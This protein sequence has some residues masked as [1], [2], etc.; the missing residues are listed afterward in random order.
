MLS[1]TLRIS[2]H[3]RLSNPNQKDKIQTTII[4]IITILIMTT[5]KIIKK[6]ANAT[7]WGYEVDLSLVTFTTLKTHPN[8]PLPQWSLC[9]LVEATVHSANT[10]KLVQPTKTSSSTSS[11]AMAPS[12]T[13]EFQSPIGRARPSASRETHG[14]S[15]GSPPRG[16]RRPLMRAANLKS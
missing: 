6:F 1:E 12:G 2:S 16:S 8:H 11:T 14:P 7:W 13:F 9:L 4:T 15:D 5:L 3:H 10:Y